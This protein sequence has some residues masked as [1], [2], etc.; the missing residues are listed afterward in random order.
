MFST[1]IRLYCTECQKIYIYSLCND[2]A[3]DSDNIGSRSL[4]E[5]SLQLQSFL[6]AQILYTLH[7][8]TVTLSAMQKDQ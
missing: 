2:G 5:I 8:I 7:T 3:R 6:S 1:Y 4:T